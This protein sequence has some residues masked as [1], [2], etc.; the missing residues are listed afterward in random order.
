[1]HCRKVRHTYGIPVSLSLEPPAATSFVITSPVFIL[2]T[3]LL[4]IVRHLVLEGTL[5]IVHCSSAPDILATKIISATSLYS[6]RTKLSVL[7]SLI[8]IHCY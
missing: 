8:S 1:M 2:A 7:L 5:L 6:S 3:P 4:S